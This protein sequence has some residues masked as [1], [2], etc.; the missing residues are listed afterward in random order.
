MVFYYNTLN[1]LTPQYYINGEPF[2]VEKVDDLTVAFKLPAVSASF[3]EMLWHNIF[4]SP[5]HVYEGREE[6]DVNILE[7]SVVGSGAFIFDGYATGEYYKYRANPDYAGG[8]VDIDELI[9]RIVPSNET[10][11]YAMLNGEANA[12]VVPSEYIDTFEGNDAFNLRSYSTGSVHYLQLNRVADSMQ[13]KAYRTGLFKALDRGE[14][15]KA[16]YGSEDRYEI[17]ASCL[18]LANPYCTDEIESYAQDIEAA[19]ELVKGGAASLKL[20]Y[21]AGRDFNEREAL[22]IQAALAQIGIQVEIFALDSA[23]YMAASYDPTNKEYDMYICTY[24]MG[25]D[26]DMYASLFDPAMGNY[27]NFDSEAIVEKFNQGRQELDHAK[28]AEIYKEAQQLIADEALIYPFGSDMSVLATTK[29][30]IGADTA[31]IH[32]MQMF[33]DWTQLSMQ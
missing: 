25:N 21:I 2:Q 30:V 6:Y 32:S 4:L 28:R 13:D 16:G 17:N 29:D 14:I 24:V 8:Q 23:A 18:P 7:E 12:W 5:E 33:L 11:A 20:A 27:L 9:Y 22:V 3:V 26:P 31:D 1:T 19:K 10:A 15:L